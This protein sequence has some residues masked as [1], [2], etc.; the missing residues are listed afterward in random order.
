MF[1]P[2]CHAEVN[3]WEAGKA[4]AVLSKKGAVKARAGNKREADSR[5]EVAEANRERIHF[6]QAAVVRVVEL[7]RRPFEHPLIPFSSPRINFGR[8]L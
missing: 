3:R 7:L 4:K 2:V 1:R 5:R 8:R 6:C